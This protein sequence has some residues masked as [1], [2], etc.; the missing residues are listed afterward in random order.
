MPA[1]EREL[2]HTFLRAFQA[3]S[4]PNV[5]VVSPDN[6]WVF[7]AIV[8]DEICNVMIALMRLQRAV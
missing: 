3:R 5:L 2:V 7:I 6:Q 1:A 8:F 4:I